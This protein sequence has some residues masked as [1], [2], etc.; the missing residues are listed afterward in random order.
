[1]SVSDPHAGLHGGATGP[2]DADFARWRRRSRLI[3]MLRRLLPAL[4]AVIVLALFGGIALSGF[5][6]PTNRL[7]EALGAIHMVN[8][9]FQGR[10]SKGRAF[11]VRAREAARDQRDQQQI[12]L[13]DPFVSLGAD[14]P[15]P[16]RLMAK[17]GM[18]RE[19][20]KMLFLHGDV[21][22]DDGSGYR[23]ASQDAV[24]D[25]RKGQVVGQGTGAADGPMGQ[26]QAGS[27]GV[28]D[29][30]KTAIFKGG[31]RARLNQH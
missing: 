7:K 16:T 27:Y 23:F 22:L 28:Y 15:T 19:N 17:T 3:H 12:L 10:D 5:L 14:T 2:R 1:L 30:G 4:M 24:V 31:V 9:R 8:P 6:A 21:R 29:K 20:D 13:Q 26:I 11:E 25:T 18:F